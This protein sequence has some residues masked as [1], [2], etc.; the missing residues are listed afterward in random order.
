MAGAKDKRSLG[1]IAD[2][3][4]QLKQRKIPVVPKQANVSEII[5]AFAASDHSRILGSLANPVRRG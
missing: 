2:L 4:E 3:M 1:K 5:D